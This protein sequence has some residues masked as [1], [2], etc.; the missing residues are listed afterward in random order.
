MRFDLAQFRVGLGE[1]ADA[2]TAEGLP[3]STARY[4]LIPDSHTFLPDREAILA[5]LPNAVAH[6]NSVYRWAW[7]DRYSEQDIDDIA[8]IIRKVVH[9]FRR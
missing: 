6:I 3:G 8:S 7:T 2:L 4:Y 9:H 1:L 5:S